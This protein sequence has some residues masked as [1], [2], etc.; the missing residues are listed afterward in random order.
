MKRTFRTSSSVGRY[1]SRLQSH[2]D[3]GTAHSSEP[4]TPTHAESW[5]LTVCIAAGLLAFA[6]LLMPRAG[7]AS[8]F[9]ILKAILSTASQLGQT[10][11]RLKAAQGSYLNYGNQVIA[12]VNQLSQLTNVLGSLQRTVFS[13]LSQIHTIPV[14]SASLSQTSAL[15]NLMYGSNPNAIRTQYTNVFGPQT[16]AVSSSI[17]NRTDMADATANDALALATNAD[18]YSTS[19]ISTAGKLQ[20]HASATAPGTADMVQAQSEVLQLYSQAV[21]HK[22]LASMLRERAEEA[23]AHSA[24]VKEVTNAHSTVK[25]NLQ[26]I[27]GGN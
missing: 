22:L 9:D 8:S 4:P 3:A 19:L 12:P 21:Q 6:V 23:A 17:A 1:V 18:T 24:E 16:T 10:A 11:S 27:L 20:T 25:G 7:N 5:S 26:K 2:C 14:R 15:E 13:Q